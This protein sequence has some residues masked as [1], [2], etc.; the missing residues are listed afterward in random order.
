MKP[1]QF[2][3]LDR[4]PTL[5]P[6]QSVRNQI[7]MTFF[8]ADDDVETTITLETEN[9][10]QSLDLLRIK[11]EIK[12]STMG[13]I[14]VVE[15]NE[16]RRYDFSE[17][18]EPVDF[19][20]YFDSGRKLILFQ[21]AKKVCR[22]VV[23]NL[24]GNPCG[25]VLAEMQVDFGK[26]LA[27][28]SEYLGAWFKGVSA[29]V[30]AAS[31]SGDQI[32]DDALF[33]SLLEKGDLS[34]VTV[35]WLYGGAEHRIMVTSRGGIVLVQDYRNNLGLELNLVFDVYERLLTKVWARKDGADEQA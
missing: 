26:I 24:R 13:F 35:P 5:K 8:G 16:R 10:E 28:C 29:R 3:L 21:A 32:Q 1:Y 15:D 20:A 7:Q 27:E 17:Y 33:R 22:G 12:H 9:F 4:F 25:V 18:L 30:R 2:Y 31:L 14:K 11:S 34:N 19:P 6:G 23:A